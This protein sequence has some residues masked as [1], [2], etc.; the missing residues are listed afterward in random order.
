MC[1]ETLSQV[2]ESIQELIARF[3]D[4]A[5]RKDAETF[6]T[7]WTPDG[8]W[9]I[10]EPLSLSVTG[11]DNIKATFDRIVCKWDFF[12]QVATSVLIEIQG[13]HAKARCTCEEF[14]INSRSGETYHNIALYFDKLSCLGEG[15]RFQRREYHYLWLDDRPL[16]GKTFPV[17]ATTTLTSGT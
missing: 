12:A 11:V 13:N 6:A 7:L 10:G 17:P 9:I 5:T 8:E 3:A 16:S 4:A 14:G 2:K 1:T 15:W